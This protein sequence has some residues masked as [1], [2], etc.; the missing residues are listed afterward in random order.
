MSNNNTADDTTDAQTLEVI[1]PSTLE[2]ADSQHDSPVEKKMS[3]LQ[4]Q[5]E[6]NFVAAT[7]DHPLVQTAG[8]KE[9]LLSDTPVEVQKLLSDGLYEDSDVFF[10]EWLQNHLAAVTREAKRRLVNEFGERALFYEIRHEHE[11]LDQPRLI[12]LPKKTADILDAAKDIGYNPTI[13]FTLRHDDGSL[14]T[15]DNGIAMTTGE[16]IDVWNEPAVSGSG[17]D[18]SSAGNKGIGSLTWVTIAGTDGAVEVQTRTKREVM[19]GD[20]VP[21]R[22]RDGYAFYTFFGGILPISKTLPDGF[23]GTR[24]KLPLGD[25]VDPDTFYDALGNYTEILPTMVSWQETQDGVKNEE[26]FERTTF[27]DRY[28]SEPAIVI[29]RPGEFTL[30]MDTPGI[31]KKGRTNDCFLLDNPIS[32]NTVYHQEF[33]TLWNDHIHIH[34]EQGLIIAGPNRG[35]RHSEVDELAGEFTDI[36]DESKPMPDVPL[37]QPVASRDSLKRDEAH[38]RFFEY[39]E[40]LAKQEEV[41]TVSDY[42]NGILNSDTPADAVEFVREQGSE[43]E[44]FRKLAKKHGGYDTFNTTGKLASWFDKRDV[45]DFDKTDAPEVQP[46]EEFASGRVNKRNDPQRDLNEHPK[47]PMLKLIYELDQDVDVATAETKGDPNLKKNRRN[48]VTFGELIGTEGKWPLFVGAKLNEDRVEVIFNDDNYSDAAVLK[49]NSY[50]KWQ[51]EPWNARLVKEVPFTHKENEDCE[52]DWTVPDSIHDAH[53]KTKTTKTTTNEKGEAI[54][55]TDP[56]N[57]QER[58]VDIRCTENSAIDVRATV[59][60]VMEALSDTD[61]DEKIIVG[62][63]NLNHTRIVI[64]PTTREPNISDHYDLSQ[65]AAL[66]RCNKSE[67]EAL[68]EFEQVCYP[69]EF[70]QHIRTTK[71]D[72][73]DPYNGLGFSQNIETILDEHSSHEYVWLKPGSIFEDAVRSNDLKDVSTNHEHYENVRRALLAKLSHQTDDYRVAFW[74]DDE[75]MRKRISTFAE[76]YHETDEHT[77]YSIMIQSEGYHSTNSNCTSHS[78]KSRVDRTIKRA[79]YPQWST[80]SDAWGKINSTGYSA[81]PQYVKDLLLACRDLGIDPDNTQNL[82]QAIVMLASTC[83]EGG[84]D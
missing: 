27:L 81:P 30:A 4:D 21:Q 82:R 15:R 1:T 74:P 78:H 23:Y 25:G 55:L 70:E 43:W 63:R 49:V 56:D 61:P 38:E 12:R 41:D 36:A 67:G 73:Y 24:F 29:D 66:I 69:E 71:V 72:V 79:Q 45:F 48:S 52:Y 2:T 39:V 58:P 51:S 75:S 17:V 83:P 77:G 46:G 62:N 7:D 32:R 33:D 26:E 18:L 68:Y 50:G 65:H 40:H 44:L 34:N 35:R 10:R 31:V 22:D 84:D 14:V 57:F 64:F 16:A 42:V 54:D 20:I 60:D 47:Y 28:P 13:E 80:G 11:D 3:E 5:L 37:P 59:G 9:A 76:F 8:S 19:N 6:R 53:V